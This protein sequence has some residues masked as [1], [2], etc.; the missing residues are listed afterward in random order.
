MISFFFFPQELLQFLPG[1]SNET[2]QKI[3][4]VLAVQSSNSA[5]K[6]D[7]TDWGRQSL[8]TFSS[9]C[10]LQQCDENFLFLVF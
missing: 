5:N 3:K 4:T 9:P 6:K 2:S 1:P 10:V 8:D 7:H